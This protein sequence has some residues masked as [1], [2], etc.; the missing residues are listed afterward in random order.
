MFGGN[1]RVV[2]DII[3]G[4]PKIVDSEEAGEEPGCI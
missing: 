3:S 2:G 1:V 4:D